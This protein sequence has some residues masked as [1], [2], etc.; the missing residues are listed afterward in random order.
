MVPAINRRTSYRR[1][2]AIKCHRRKRQT[3]T[4]ISTVNGVK[5]I[6]FIERHSLIAIVIYSKTDENVI[7]LSLQEILPDN[8]IKKE[9]T[10]VSNPPN[11]LKRAKVLKME[12]EVSHT[13]SL[14]TSLIIPVTFVSKL[15]RIRRNGGGFIDNNKLMKSIRFC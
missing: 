12:N 3:S 15:K 10:L 8:N 9:K 14:C 2:T 7:G 6:A 13:I 4:T 5:I 1:L 11:I